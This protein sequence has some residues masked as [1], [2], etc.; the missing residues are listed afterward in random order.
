[1]GASGGDRLIG[2]GEAE[3]LPVI[4]SGPLVQIVGAE[5]IARLAS[6]DVEGGIVEVGEID[7]GALGGAEVASHSLDSVAV[8]RLGMEAGSGPAAQDG[9]GAEDGMIDLD[10]VQ[11]TPMPGREMRRSVG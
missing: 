11:V 4:P 9:Y 6:D 10:G 1:M 7:G 8:T 5:K 2:K 3:S